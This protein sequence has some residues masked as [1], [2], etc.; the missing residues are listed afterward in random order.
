MKIHIIGGS[1]TGKSFISEKISRQYGIP[2]YDLDNIF[3]D[4]T[5][6][7]YGV[8][9][10]IEKRTLILHDILK[11]DNWIIEGVYYDWLIDS[12]CEADKIF[13][14]QT[15]HILFNSRIII[16]FIKR[17]LGLEKGKKE[18]FKSF[19][20]L[21]VWTNKYQKNNIP[22]ILEFLKPYHEKVFLLKNSNNIYQYLNTN[23]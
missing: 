15:S 14:L 1:G 6:N 3:W 19:K 16:R 8:K 17:K 9:M 18:T 5:A 4:N 22:L 11:N 21:I 13:I 2:H 10:P 12:F 23:K 7:T 20:R